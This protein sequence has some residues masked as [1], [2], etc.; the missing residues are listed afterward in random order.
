MM[1]RNPEKKAPHRRS[2]FQFRRAARVPLVR[3]GAMV[4]IA[5][6]LFA[7]PNLMS[8]QGITGT[9]SGRVTD[10]QGAVVPGAQVTVTNIATGVATTRTTNGAGLYS[11]PSLPSGQYNITIT[12]SGFKG[13]TI[14][15][16]ILS[17]QG[18]VNRDTMLEPGAATSTVTVNAGTNSINTTTAT[19]STVINRQFM[20]NMPLNGRSFQSL[21]ELTPG[22]NPAVTSAGSQ[23][24][25]TVNGQ[26]A[27]SNYYTVD[28]VS[29]N[30]GGVSESTLEAGGGSLPALSAQGGTNSLVSVDAVQ[31]FRIQ[32]STYAPEFG[33]TPGAQIAIETRSGTN[34]FHGNLFDYF[35]ND[36]LDANNWF[37]NNL[38]LRRPAEHVNDFGGTFGGPLYR[39]KAF[40]FFSYEGLRLTLP[41]TVETEVPANTP[42]FDPLTG[43]DV[44]PRTAAPPVLQPF[45]NA[46]PLPS[47]PGLT[48]GSMLAPFNS[49]Y[50]N[51]STLNS[52]SIRIDDSLGKNW[53]IFGRYSDAPSSNTSRGPTSGGAS[54][55][56]LATADFDARSLTAAATWLI[57]NQMTNDLRFNYGFSKADIGGHLDNFG[58]AVVPPDSAI[59]PASQP[60]NTS[61]GALI[62]VPSLLGIDTALLNGPEADDTQTQYNIVDNFSV[63]KGKH[64]LKFGVD[65]RRLT[66]EYAPA[67]YVYAPIY[68]TIPFAVANLPFETEVGNQRHAEIFVHNLGLYAQDTWRTTPRLT[69]TY[70]VRWDIDFTPTLGGDLNF[71]AVTGFGGNG[72]NLAIA[73]PG[74]PV[75]KTTYGNFAPRVGFNYQWNQNPGHETILRGGYGIFYDLVSQSIG[76][77]ISNLQYPFGTAN[78]L[79]GPGLG[80]GTVTLPL[81]PAE[82]APPPISLQTPL[83]RQT[84]FNPNLK[85][86]YSHEYN[87]AVERAL[88]PS[89][90]FSVSYVGATGRR[91]LQSSVGGNV[92]STFSAVTAIDNTSTSNYNSLQL[93]FKRQVTQGLQAVAAYTW[94]HS[95]DTASTGSGAGNDDYIVLGENPNINRGPSDF[96][97]RNSGS[98]GLTYTMPKLQGSLL[99]R[100]L[101]GGWSL[102]TL[103][104]AYSASPLTVIDGNLQFPTVTQVA[105]RPDV[106][107]GVPFYLHGNVCTN[108]ATLLPENCPGGKRINH[109]AFKDPPFTVVNGVPIP[110]RQGTLGRNSLRGLGVKQWDFSFHRDFLLPKTLDLQFRAEMFNIVNHPNFGGFNTDFTTP[111]QPTFGQATTTLGQALGSGGVNGGFNPLFQIGGPRSIQLALKLMF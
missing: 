40:F 65:Y 24:Q 81:T 23:G 13:T 95:I 7:L 72:S 94:S 51:P 15:G 67:S 33:R 100:N 52:W 45:F 19:V 29:A 3:I 44:N 9:I 1:I 42:V 53:K 93:Q 17:V 101:L 77:I 41:Q 6:S 59:Y 71:V 56:S 18:D 98:L 57:T 50:S 102:D 96:D 109:A 76:S 34:K 26:R 21:I 10:T 107:A 110:L 38:N 83:T 61:N 4:A 99:R 86:P 30:F 2:I 11:V 60:F 106:V 85:L 22:V 46:F 80:G 37:N 12:A 89:Q 48:D 63:D 32:T 5:L 87:L 103:V 31:E 20:E 27:N 75:Y 108:P 90:S 64:A 58:G 97:I 25:F 16:V 39:N 82:A 49:S 91:L 69:L 70:G 14:N 55:N 28:G 62:F 43:T 104:L 88:G 78:L 68:F 111:A 54:V 74:T 105:V 47:G 79:L 35:R 36:A 84:V 66:P 73:P 92:N 8:A